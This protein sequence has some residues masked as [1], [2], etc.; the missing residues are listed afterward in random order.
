MIYHRFWLSVNTFAVRG[1]HLHVFPRAVFLIVCAALFCVAFLGHARLNK[2]VILFVPCIFLAVLDSV[3]FSG[4]VFGS[5]WIAVCKTGSIHQL[6]SVIF[7][8]LFAEYSGNLFEYLFLIIQLINYFF[9]DWELLFL[10]FCKVSLKDLSHLFGIR[11]FKW[12]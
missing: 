6:G 3:W 5:W 2:M 10:G 8:Y 9:E 7:T 11:I 1:G 4:G 12:G